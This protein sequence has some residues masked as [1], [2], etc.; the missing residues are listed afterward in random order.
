MDQFSSSFVVLLS[1]SVSC[2]RIQIVG[3]RCNR[4]RSHNSRRP[5]IISLRV[6]NHGADNLCA[7][8]HQLSNCEPTQTCLTQ[9]PGLIRQVFLNGLIQDREFSESLNF[10]HENFQGVALMPARTAVLSGFAR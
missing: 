10:G 5:S 1:L 6:V 3:D 2:A 8:R 7:L 4:R 9:W